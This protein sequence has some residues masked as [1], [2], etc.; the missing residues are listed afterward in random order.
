MR[1]GGRAGLEA[2]DVNDQDILTKTRQLRNKQ[3]HIQFKYVCDDGHIIQSEWMSS[4]NARR[5]LMAW[6]DTVRRVL[7]DRAEALAR[8]K[9]QKAQEAN[10][11]VSKLILPEGLED[12]TP[13]PNYEE[14]LKKRKEQFVEPEVE[15]FEEDE[16]EAPKPRKKPKKAKRPPVFE[17][18]DEDDDDDEIAQLIREQL[19]QAQAQARKAA[20]KVLKLKRLLAAMGADDEDE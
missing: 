5:G 10:E 17:Y 20:K 12:G 2:S 19:L 1:G 4:D 9:R 16:E 14:M 7:V 15:E 8:E 11:E 18:D 13:E 6:C 3:D